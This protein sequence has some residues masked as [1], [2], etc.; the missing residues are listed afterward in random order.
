MST[1]TYYYNFRYKNGPCDYVYGGYNVSGGGFWNGTTNV[2]GV[3]T[4]PSEDAHFQYIPTNDLLAWFPMNGDANDYSGNNNNG[5][6][7]GPTTANDRN[8]NSNSAYLF[9]GSND[10]IHTI[11]DLNVTTN[12]N[13]D[14]FT[15]SA[16]VK[17][18]NAQSFDGIVYF[19]NNVSMYLC[20]DGGFSIQSNGANA[21]SCPSGT[22]IEIF[23]L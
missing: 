11:P 23:L 19:S 22:T 14:E 5:T 7:D 20:T 8:G 10:Y 18:S 15:V 13:N 12:A 1:G 16:W 17:T 9:D 4:V 2:N 3:L 6:L 21:G